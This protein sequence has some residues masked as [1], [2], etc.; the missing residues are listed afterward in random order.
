MNIKAIEKRKD[1]LI[2][3]NFLSYHYVYREYNDSKAISNERVQSLESERY[4]EALLLPLVATYPHIRY[5]IYVKSGGHL[6]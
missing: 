4:V 2:F 3:P 6:F 1:I 5:F